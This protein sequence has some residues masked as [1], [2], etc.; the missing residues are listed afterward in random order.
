MT[1]GS[2]LAGVVGHSATASATC[3]SISGFNLGTGCHS[4]P[5]SLAIGLGSGATAHAQKPFTIDLRVMTPH[6]PASWPSSFTDL[7]SAIAALFDSFTHHTPKK[8][9]GDKAATDKAAKDKAATD[10]AA[11][12]K[13]ATDKAATDKA[14]TDKAATDKAATD[15]AATDKAATDK[16]ATDKAATDKAAAEKAAADKAAAD[17]K[18]AED[19][20]AADKKAAE[21]KAAADKKAADDKTLAEKVAKAKAALDKATADAEAA[22]KANDVAWARGPAYPEYFSAG[23][24]N[25]EAQEALDKAQAEY[26]A[27]TTPPYVPDPA[28]AHD[29]NA[30][31]AAVDKAEAEKAAAD[32]AVTA[33]SAQKNTAM[34]NAAARRQRKA[35]AELARADAEYNEALKAQPKSVDASSRDVTVR[36]QGEFDEVPSVETKRDDPASPT[37][38][39]VAPGL[40]TPGEAAERPRMTTTD[41]SKVEQEQPGKHGAASSG[42]MSDPTDV[43]D[44]STDLEGAEGPRKIT[45]SVTDG[46]DATGTRSDRVPDDERQNSPST[47]DDAVGDRGAP[48]PADS[49][50]AAD[51]SPT[52]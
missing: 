31:K 21:D 34:V 30:K 18:A 24:V 14:A 42:S 44:R 35:D 15:K 29:V 52:K 1:T 7:R 50:S 13:A 12:D 17:K 2:L 40:T 28:T 25:R 47:K 9:P 27:L 48:S 8:A 32:A 51:E 22:E 45:A 36:T 23:T 10:K 3:L 33:A 16:A 26:D 39:D 43:D 4:A 20:A 46:G 6:G 38:A 49:H 19:K 11:T 5:F 41:P 37:A